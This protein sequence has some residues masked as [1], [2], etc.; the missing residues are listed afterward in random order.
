[1][2]CVIPIS[3]VTLGLIVL[4][5]IFPASADNAASVLS[6]QEI[7]HLLAFIKSAPCQFNRNGEWHPAAKAAEHIAQKYQYAAN[8]GLV[9][10]AEDF[11]EQAATQSSMS[12]QSYRVKC[13]ADPELRS[14]DWLRDELERYRD[15]GLRAR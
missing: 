15:A 2:R 4:L 1:M 9:A 7:E 5:T 14:A 11:I 13:G 12:G 3:T 10:S 6:R 8:K